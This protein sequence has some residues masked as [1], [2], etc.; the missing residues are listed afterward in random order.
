MA[1]DFRVEDRVELVVLA[2]LKIKSEES[3]FSTFGTFELF[4][5]VVI[6]IA[7][8]MPKHGNGSY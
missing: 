2:N 4:D 3:T 7:V 1:V 5:S 6:L 8:R